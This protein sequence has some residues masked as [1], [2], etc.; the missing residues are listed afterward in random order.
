MLSA[1][2]RLASHV[3][4]LKLHAS[5][6]ALVGVENLSQTV[7]DIAEHMHALHTFHWGVISTSTETMWKRLRL[8]YVVNFC[9]AIDLD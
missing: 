7:A 3:H 6:D 9:H 1:N 5:E 2:P 8:Q 4:S